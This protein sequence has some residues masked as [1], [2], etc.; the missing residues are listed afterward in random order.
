MLFR[1]NAV[2]VFAAGC[3]SC[4]AGN[5]C[6]PSFIGGQANINYSGAAYS[7]NATSN[8]TPSSSNNPIITFGR[9]SNAVA[10]AIGY[11]DSQTALYIG[12]TTAHNLIIKSQSTIAATFLNSGIA[13]FANTACASTFAGGVFSGTTFCTSNGIIGNNSNNLYLS[14]NSAAGEDR[15]ST[16]LNSSH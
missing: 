16:R 1:S 6:A 4:F 9:T 13:L 10:G 15:K 7:I 8:W 14:S 5:V 11:D 2:K 3:V 12:T